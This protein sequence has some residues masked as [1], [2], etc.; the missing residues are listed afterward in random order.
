[1]PVVRVR[2][3]GRHHKFRVL[4]RYGGDIVN[5]TARRH[6]IDRRSLRVAWVSAV[7]F[8]RA[9]VEI[10]E[11]SSHAPTPDRQAGSRWQTS[12][13]WSELFHFVMAIAVS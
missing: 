3:R 1:M 9:L 2:N 4:K 5:E 13:C 12:P 11:N 7:P 10:P 8:C 6:Q